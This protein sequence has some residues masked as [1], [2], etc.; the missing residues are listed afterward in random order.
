MLLEVVLVFGK[1][2]S[3]LDLLGRRGV[4]FLQELVC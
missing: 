1:E 4:Q 2:G 3:L